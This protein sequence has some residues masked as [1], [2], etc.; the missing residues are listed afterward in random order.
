MRMTEIKQEDGTFKRIDFTDLK[1]G[2]VFRL[3]ES[4]G[5]PVTTA[6]GHE[7][8]TATSDPFLNEESV[9]TIDI[10]IPDLME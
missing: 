4:T 10:N 1:E 7:E 8:F 3:F 6:L 9:W 5:E 2:D